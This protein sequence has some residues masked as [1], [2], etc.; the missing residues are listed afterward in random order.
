[1]PT[2]IDISANFFGSNDSKD[3]PPFMGSLIIA[4]F[5]SGNQLLSPFRNPNST[6]PFG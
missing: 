5:F 2:G 3:A 1:M 6:K 4:Y